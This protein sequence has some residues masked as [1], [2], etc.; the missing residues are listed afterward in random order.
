MADG[1][2]TRLCRALPLVTCLISLQAFA[3]DDQALHYVETTET[4]ELTVPAG[5]VA[6]VIPREGFARL[7]PVES[8]SPDWTFDLIDEPRGIEIFGT[9]DAAARYPG[10]RGV[11]AKEIEDLKIEDAPTPRNV[12]FSSEGDWEVIHYEIARDGR[13]TSYVRAD[14]VEAEVWIDAQIEV[15]G[16]GDAEAQR[17]TALDL[18]R[19]LEVRKT[20]FRN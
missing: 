12:Q 4:L 13:L 20:S 8:G 17:E 15:S 14:I 18:L 6:L 11:W 10:I 7:A 1:T 5:G 9:F 16:T 2:A 19:S 3:T